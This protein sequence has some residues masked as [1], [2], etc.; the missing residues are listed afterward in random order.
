MSV[1][2]QHRADVGRALNALR[3]I[4]RALRV[5][6]RATEKEL[7]ISGAQLFVLQQLAEKPADS[8]NDLAERTLTHQR[9]VS[10]VVAR[11]AEQ[12]LVL[13]E[14]SRLDARRSEIALTPAGR[15]LLDRSGPTLQVRLAEGLAQLPEEQRHQL[16]EGLDAWLRAT[17]I[18]KEEATLFFEETLPRE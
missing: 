9:S 2:D 10:V 6:A 7:G 8:I 15:A 4:V 1:T 11:L 17:G 14:A 13:R 5:S 12:G 3:K 16:V 18:D